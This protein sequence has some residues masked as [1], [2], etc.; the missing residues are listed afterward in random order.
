MTMPH[1]RTRSIIQARDFLVD[2]SR[3]QALPESIRNEARRLLRH[4]PTSKEILLA[5]KVEEQMKN[6]LPTPFLSSKI[7]YEAVAKNLQ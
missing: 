1:E 2:L 4:Y 5:G 7:D 3:N 6:G